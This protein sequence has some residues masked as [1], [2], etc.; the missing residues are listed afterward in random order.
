MIKLSDA[1]IVEYYCQLHRTAL[2]RD[3]RDDLIAI[4]DPGKVRLAN[5]FTDYAHRLGM[6][7]AFAYLGKRFGS[8]SGLSVLDLGCG[9]GRWV[10][11][12]SVRGAYVT[13]VDISQEALDLLANEMPQHSFLRQNLTQLTVPAASFDI[14]NSV[15]VLQHLT[16]TAQQNLLHVVQRS[17]KAGGYLVLFENVLDF[18]APHVFPHRTEEWLHMAATAGLRCCALWGSNFEILF[19]AMS[20]LVGLIHLSEQ[21]TPVP[22]SS[23]PASVIAHIKSAVNELVASVSFPLERMLHSVPLADPTH[24]VMIFHK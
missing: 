7:K 17:L 6:G 13:G 1:E 14:V 22:S 21:P 10:R 23:R 20:R 24:S 11:E 12:Y 4:I 2:K 5:R 3:Q 18:H 16:N 15:T 8:L 19:R 9:R